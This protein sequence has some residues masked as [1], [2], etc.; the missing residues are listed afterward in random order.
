MTDSAGAV[1]P[2][3]FRPKASLRMGLSLS[4]SLVAA[5]LLGW[6]M[7]APSVRAQFTPVQILTLLF[8]L[9]LLVGLALGIGLSYV[10]ADGAGL[11]F[12]N[13]IK[14]YEVPWSQVKAFRYRDG[15]PWPF[16]LV[17]S[18]VEQRPLLGIQRSDRAY[19][20]QCVAE[21]R[22]RLEAAYHAGTDP[23]VPSP[24]PPDDPLA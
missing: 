18:E 2:V 3:T 10:R 24:P 23:V 6:V 7:T 4:I 12:R 22:E 11:R 1:R 20:E 14:T 5:A 19:A 9:A 16:V 21:L 8:F 13:G 17:R 15:D